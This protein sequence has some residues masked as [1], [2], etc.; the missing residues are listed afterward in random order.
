VRLREEKQ[1]FCQLGFDVSGERTLVVLK[2][3]EKRNAIM[4]NGEFCGEY[5]EN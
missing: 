1:E 5:S 2:R 3:G 4:E